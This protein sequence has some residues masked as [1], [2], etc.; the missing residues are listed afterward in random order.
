[1]SMKKEATELVRQVRLAGW[2]VERDGGGHWRCTPPGGG[3]YVTLPG[4]P[5]DRRT[6]LNVKAKLKRFGL[7]V[8]AEVQT[9]GGPPGE[10]A[11][12][13]YDAAAKRAEEARIAAELDAAKAQPKQMRDVSDFP[14]PGIRRVFV[15]LASQK[16]D[17]FRTSG[18]IAE[19]VSLHRTSVGRAARWLIEQELVEAGPKVSRE[20]TYRATE[21]GVEYLEAIVPNWDKRQPEPEPTVEEPEPE[22]PTAP[23]PE[24]SRVEMV[25]SWLVEVDPEDSW[26][27]QGLLTVL[28]WVKQQDSK[29]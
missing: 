3:E 15:F 27:A 19:R 28:T 20:L 12:R 17:A 4:T 8:D 9:K 18:A 10:A 16:T 29:G 23:V 11:Q 26:A 2:L 14:T 22:E 7:D 13:R 1:M 25:A 24:V 6:L 5:S 21:F